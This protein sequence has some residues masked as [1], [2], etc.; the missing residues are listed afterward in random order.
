MAEYL[1]V[2]RRGVAQVRAHGGIRGALWQLLRINDLKTGELV[3]VDKYGN[4]YYENTSYFFGRHRWVE[5]TSRMNDKNTYWEVDGS[6]VPPEWHCWLHS[7]TDNPPTTH[8]PIPRKFI[9]ENHKFNLSGTAKQYVPY[10]TTR[11]K[12]HE[13]VPPQ[14]LK[15]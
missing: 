14:T 12:I 3:G 4:K 15:K 1:Q 10:S 8:P 13:W 11:K 5:Y 6:M 7:I 9:W 2:L